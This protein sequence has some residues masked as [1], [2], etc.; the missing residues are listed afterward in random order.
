MLGGGYK[1]IDDR[2]SP[3]KDPSSFQL[4]LQ[5]SLVPFG[6]GDTSALLCA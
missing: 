3:P 1:S 4:I 5:P 2:A 6:K